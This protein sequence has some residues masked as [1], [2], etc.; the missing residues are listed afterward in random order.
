VENFV[1]AKIELGTSEPVSRYACDTH[2]HGLELFVVHDKVHK[3]ALDQHLA[4][5][6]LGFFTSQRMTKRD[7]AG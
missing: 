7:D 2:K 4:V 3:T 6:L 1:S 5:R